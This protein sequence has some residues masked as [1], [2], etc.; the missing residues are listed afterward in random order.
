MSCPNCLDCTNP[1]DEC[2]QNVSPTPEPYTPQL[3]PCDTGCEFSVS[4][5]CTTLSED[6]ELCGVE[7]PSGT[8]LS[9][10]LIDLLNA[11]CCNCT[12]C[13]GI[14][15]TLS[16]S[17][18]NIQKKLEEFDTLDSNYFTK[19][20]VINFISFV[21][22]TTT[23]DT[24]KYLKF[25][26]PDFGVNTTF[27]INTTSSG[28]G[29][30][31]NICCRDFVNNANPT[32]YSEI[33]TSR[34][35]YDQ[36]QGYISSNKID[37]SE[38]I[39]EPYRF[40]AQ[41]NSMPI[42][43]DYLVDSSLD[44]GLLYYADTITNSSK[45]NNNEGSVI[46]KINLNTREITTISGKKGNGDFPTIN[47]LDGSQVLYGRASSIVLDF[48]EV[49]NNEPVMYFCTF[50][51]SL[52][53]PNNIT[54][55]GGVICRLVKE[56]NCENCDERT[57]WTTHVIGNLNN[58]FGTNSDPASP[59]S[60]DTITFKH[61][62]G[63]KRWFDINGAPS[64]YIYDVVEGL[65][66][67]MYHTGDGSMNSASNWM[68]QQVTIPSSLSF[69]NE[70]T[71]MTETYPIS[72]GGIS[73][74]LNVDDYEGEGGFNSRRLILTTEKGIYHFNWTSN[75]ATTISEAI[76]FTAPGWSNQVVTYNSSTCLN[77]LEVNG[78]FDATSSSNTTTVYDP[79]FIAKLK[80][81]KYIYGTGRS[82]ILKTAIRAYEEVSQIAFN[83][84]TAVLELNPTGIVSPTTI[85]QT[86]GNTYG[87]VS[88]INGLSEGFFYDLQNNLYD[89]TYG[90]IRLWDDDLN[91]CITFIGQA[92]PGDTELVQSLAS[93]PSITYRMDTQYEMS[94]TF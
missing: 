59:L 50:G 47:G 12:T 1:C 10:L 54:E 3:P 44:L 78:L 19:N 8:P 72:L 90:G 6:M 7:Y 34:N 55:K 76:D 30:N 41:I 13:E 66:Y 79:N 92:N 84:T 16:F 56:S 53:N 26:I 39:A 60:G 18:S 38:R 33:M 68:F 4:T 46:R 48:E 86:I 61:L 35:C 71:G 9:Q 14:V 37:Y 28:I 2:Q 25:N 88:T 63:L 21:N 77:T 74:N 31:V 32:V 80:D 81:G 45:I 11:T 73:S 64:F 5:Q 89:M 69:Y 22:N 23:N 67:Y 17:L 91:N 36:K 27:D 49:Y 62:Y 65:L 24:I 52:N 57:N 51:T 15:N 85:R 75:I 20:D 40:N 83:H 58:G 94:L 82:N 87:S 70:E 29:S 43:R 42:Y 93:S